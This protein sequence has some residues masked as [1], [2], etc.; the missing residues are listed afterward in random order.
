MNEIFYD[1][2]ENMKDHRFE[3]IN[4]LMTASSVRHKRDDCSVTCQRLDNV[5][6][7]LFSTSFLLSLS[8]ILEGSEAKRSNEDLLEEATDAA[9][10]FTL[11]A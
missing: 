11:M 10:L 7:T 6:F 5:A 9:R 4:V 3:Y 8:V 2:C 1:Q